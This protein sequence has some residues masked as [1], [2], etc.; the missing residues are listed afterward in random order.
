M[1]KKNHKDS[2]QDDS[3]HQTAQA[4]AS[5]P[6]ASEVP[7]SGSAAELRPDRLGARLRP[8]RLGAR[9]RP[10]RLGAKLRP[11]RLG[12]LARD[13]PAWRLTEDDALL[14]TWSFPEPLTAA[15]FA[16]FVATLTDATAQP[17]VIRQHQGRVTVRLTS[18]EVGGLTEEDF[19]LA[20]QLGG[21]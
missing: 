6:V 16:L 19:Q 14:R 9:L 20:R 13:V 18:P 11:D 15:C 2:P 21:A 10:D 7:D 3:A 4:T 5:G 17:A 12:V 1:S 8:D